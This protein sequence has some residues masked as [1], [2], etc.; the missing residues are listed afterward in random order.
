MGPVILVGCEGMPGATALQRGA[1]CTPQMLVPVTQIFADGTVTPY[2]TLILLV[3]DVPD[4]NGGNDH[5]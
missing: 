4:A 5:E 3:A 2:V 1:V